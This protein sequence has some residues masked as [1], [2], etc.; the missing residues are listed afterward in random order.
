MRIPKTAAVYGPAVGFGVG[1]AA[2][3]EKRPKGVGGQE[4]C[5]RAG[6]ATEG[7][8]VGRRPKLFRDS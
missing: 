7:P 8:E 2:F 4:R 3:P 6:A 1:V 5:R